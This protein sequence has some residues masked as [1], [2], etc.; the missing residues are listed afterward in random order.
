M[1]ALFFVLSRKDVQM[2]ILNH[3]LKSAFAR[4]SSGINHPPAVDSIL[5]IF[6]AIILHQS[7]RAVTV[8]LIKKHTKA[9]LR[10]TYFVQLV[11]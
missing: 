5:M 6:I 4:V 10:Q 2:P 3:V 11:V 7:I 1:G 9:P 8:L